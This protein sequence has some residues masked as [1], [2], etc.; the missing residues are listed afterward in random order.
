MLEFS[1]IYKQER[2]METKTESEKKWRN[3]GEKARDSAVPRAK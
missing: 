1:N 3:M 2:K